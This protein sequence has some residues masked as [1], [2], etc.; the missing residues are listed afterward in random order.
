MKGSEV[1]VRDI[2][3]SNIG[4]Y[5]KLE[6]QCHSTPHNFPIQRKKKYRKRKGKGK[7]KLKPITAKK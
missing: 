3:S 5:F 6:L 4:L 2:S 7:G 1:S